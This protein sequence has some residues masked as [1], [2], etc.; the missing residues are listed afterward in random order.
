[1]AIV[2]NLVARFGATTTGFDRGT[3][4]V[5]GGLA[6]ITAGVTRMIGMMAPLAGGALFVSMTRNAEQFSRKMNQSLAIMG[7]VSEETQK[8]MS[9]AAFRAA[10]DTVFSAEQAAESY[11]F[12]ASAGLSAAQSLAAIP[13]VAQ[14]AQAGMFSMARATD[15]LTDAQSAL[16]LTVEDSAQNMENMLRVS[17]VLVKANTLANASVQ[18]FSE[19]LTNKAGA[20]LK[21]VNKDI[22]EGVAVLA[23]FADQ[24]LKAS[25][26]GTALNIVFRDLQTKSLLNQQAF[27]DAGIAVFSLS[28]DMRNMADIIGDIERRLDGMSDAQKKATLLQLGFTDKSVIFLQTLIGMSE[29]IR[30]YEKELRI[31]GGTTKDVADKQMTPLQKAMERL[32]ATSTEL[33]TVF[34]EQVIPSVVKFLEATTST[35]RALRTLI[36]III[37]VGGALI[38]YTL[39]LQAVAL[40]QTLVTA[41]SGPKGWLIIAGGITVA[42]VAAGV[43]ASQ[44]ESIQTEARNALS[45]IQDI[46]RTGLGDLDPVDPVGIDFADALSGIPDMGS[47]LDPIQSALKGLQKEFRVLSGITDEGTEAFRKFAEGGATGVELIQFRTLQMGSAIEKARDKLEAEAKGMLESALT[48]QERI[49]ERIKRINALTAAGFLNREERLRVL[50]SLKVEV[51]DSTEGQGPRFA[52]ALQAGSAE[53]FSAIIAATRPEQRNQREIAKNTKRLAELAEQEAINDA[54]DR[55]EQEVVVVIPAMGAA[56]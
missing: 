8:K 30:A 23:A 16:G 10:R 21:I 40:A 38:A 2:A 5:R 12:L 51:D 6:S 36:P 33:G 45:A 44:L 11:F 18:Q 49:E 13:L 47:A 39:I 54:V 28:G 53:A 29:R 9:K 26:A 27:K 24:G 34:N 4:R 3:K 41:L 31:A 22:E 56:Q 52:A 14:F 7:D 19:A 55:A 25:D 1:M 48:P 43:M 20:A 42:A 37:T 15:L 17:D 50:E 32:K 35:L 46:D